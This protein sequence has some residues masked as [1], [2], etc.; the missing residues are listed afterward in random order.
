MKKTLPSNKILIVLQFWDGDKAQAMK[1]ARLLADLEDT[2]SVQADFL[3]VARFDSHHDTNAVRYVSR[4]FNTHTH[5]SRRRGVGW[6]CGCNSLFFGGLEWVYHKMNAGQIPHYRGVL[7]LGADSVPLEKD[8]ISTML[9]GW[10]KVNKKKKVYLAGA[11]AEAGG[12][13]HINGDCILLSGD[14]DFLKWLAVTV[15]DVSV[16][17]GWDWILS[18]EFASWGWAD[19]SFVKSLWRKPTFTEAEWTIY[20]DAGVSWVHGVKDDSLLEIAR[21]N[22]C[23]MIK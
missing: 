19:F 23:L 12:R 3:F 16:A 17:A 13:V 6:P 5:T 7:I 10:S 21:K 11:M 22:L 2:H 9:A 8:W 4:R 15:G 20:K 18:E 1:L 14:L